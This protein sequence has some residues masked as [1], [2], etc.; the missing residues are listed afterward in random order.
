[1]HPLFTDPRFKKLP[2]QD[3]HTLFNAVMAKEPRW[4]KTPP[5]LRRQI[6]AKVIQ[7]SF[8]I[9]PPPKLEPPE[10]TVQLSQEPQPGV[11]ETL[12][13]PFDPVEGPVHLR[14]ETYQGP[15][16]A[17][18]LA[19]K[20][21][22]AILEGERHARNAL[23]VAE[24]PGDIVQDLIRGSVEDPEGTRDELRTTA[25]ALF[26]G[27]YD[28]MVPDK[29]AH[30]F[31]GV[32]RPQ[33]P[34]TPV[35]E[36]L[37][38]TGATMASWVPQLKATL[39]HLGVS[40]EDVAQMSP[41]QAEF[42]RQ[43]I[44]ENY[45]KAEYG[46]RVA[47]RV[48]RGLSI[49]DA[50]SP[51]DVKEWIKRGF[52]G[53]A[54]IMMAM[55]GAGVL[56]GPGAAIPVA[57]GMETASISGD[58]YD[59]TGEGSPFASIVGGTI[60][61]AL[62][63][64]PIVRALRRTGLG[65]EAVEWM[66]SR[67][68]AGLATGAEEFGTEYLQ[69][70]VESLALEFAKKHKEELAAEGFFEHGVEAVRTVAQ[71]V[72][73]PETQREALNAGLIGTMTGG[74]TGA[75]TP[76][77]PAAQS[78]SEEEVAQIRELLGALKPQEQQ[79]AAPE[80]EA[81]PAPPP[82]AGPQIGEE[83][84]QDPQ[85]LQ[86]ALDE[87]RARAADT[88]LAPPHRMQWAN[89]A[90]EVEQRLDQLN[91]EILAAQEP[92]TQTPEPAPEPVSEAAPT[93]AP[94]EAETQ[95]EAQEA[96]RF[97]KRKEGGYTTT[98]PDG[99]EVVVT[100]TTIPGQGDQKETSVWEA[101]LADDGIT[102]YG[103]TRAAAY[104]AA[105]EAQQ[106]GSQAPETEPSPAPEPETA[107]VLPFPTG[108]QQEAPTETAP[109]EA[110]RAP[111]LEPRSKGFQI[112]LDGLD[113]ATV[114]RIRD[115]KVKTKAGER[116]LSYHPGDNAVLVPKTRRDEIA[117]QLEDILEVPGDHEAQGRVPRGEREAGQAGQA[118]A[119][120]GP[121]QDQ[122]A[123]PEEAAAGGVPQAET[124]PVDELAATPRA[125][126][127]GLPAP[128]E[129]TEAPRTKFE[130][131]P[132]RLTRAFE[133][134]EIEPTPYGAI[135]KRNGKEQGRVVLVGQI[136]PTEE[137]LAEHGLTVEEWEEG[138][139][140]IT[141]A[142][143]RVKGRN[144]IRI[145]RGAADDTTLDHEAFHLVWT[146]LS[147]AA[148][149]SLTKK[150]GGEEGAA[151]AYETWEPK[152]GG[153]L[154]KVWHWANR[155]A[156]S[157]GI[158][159]TADYVLG[160]IRSG[161][162][163]ERAAASLEGPQERFQVKSRDDGVDEHTMV[164]PN[165]K[166]VV[167][168]P[169]KVKLTKQERE[170]IKGD[171]EAEARL[172]EYRADHPTRDG[173]ARVAV[174]EVEDG[175]VTYE[176]ASY[177]FHLDPKTKE[178]NEATEARRIKHLARKMAKDVLEV[179]AKA[180]SGD[181]NSNVILRQQGWYRNMRGKLRDVLG[182]NAELFADFLGTFSPKTPVPINWR[183][184]VE[185]IQRFSRGDYDADMAKFKKWID[186]GKSA[187]KY[188]GPRIRKLGG[189]LFGTNSEKGMIAL[190]DMWQKVDKGTSPKAR[191]FTRNLLGYSE[192][193]T[194]DV[195]AARYLQ[196]LAGLRRIPPKM[197][198]GVGGRHKQN[199]AQKKRD[200]IENLKRT[201]AEKGETSSRRRALEKHRAELAQ[202]VT[203]EQLRIQRSGTPYPV[204][205]AFGFAQQV[206][207]EA[208]EMLAK[209]GV[210]LPPA[211]L[212]AVAWFIEKGEWGQK[213]FDTEVGGSFE[214]ELEADPV[215][216]FISGF[217]PDREE[218]QTGERLR[219]TEGSAR[220]GSTKVLQSL[221]PEERVQEAQEGA[222]EA[223]NIQDDPAVISYR[224][225]ETVG[226]YM[227]NTESA[228]DVELT[229][230][231]G[232]S[233]HR[234][235]RHM[236]A[237]AKKYDQDSVFFSRVV[238]PNEDVEGARPGIEVYF[239]DRA[240]LEDAM[241]VID[242]IVG[243]GH[244][245]F[246]FMVDPR[247][248]KTSSEEFTGVRLQYIPEFDETIDMSDPKALA[249]RLQEKQDELDALA[250]TL[251]GRGDVF[252]ARVYDYDTLVV[253]KED[254]DA[255]SSGE[256]ERTAQASRGK[257]WPRHAVRKDAA[258]ADQAVGGDRGQVAA[259]DV[260]QRAGPKGKGE[261]GKRHQVRSREDTGAVE[262]SAPPSPRGR[263]EYSKAVIPKF[264]T[265]DSG[266]VANPPAERIQPAPIKGGEVKRIDKIILKVGKG[267]G[268]I[269][270][271]GKTKKGVWGTYFP[272]SART[273]IKFAGDLDTAAHELA[274]AI[275][276]MFGIAGRLNK[277]REDKL[278]RRYYK[279]DKV[280]D[281]ELE[282]F[283]VY[284]SV[285]EQGPRSRLPYKRAE[286]FAEWLRAY[287]VNPKAAVEAAPN[288]Y[289]LYRETVSDEVH[290]AIEQFS[291]D[292]REHAGLSSTD[293]TLANVRVEPDSKVAKI[294][295]AVRDEFEPSDR[296]IFTTLRWRDRLASK[297]T[298]DLHPLF[299]GVAR[300]L[301]IRGIDHLLPKDDPRTL[302][303]LW[304]GL[305]DKI[306]AIFEMGMVDA[307]NRPMLPGGI[308]WLIG[309]IDPTSDESVQRGY[310]GTISL[311]ISERV[312]EKGRA[313]IDA[314][315]EKA[316][317]WQEA[318][319]DGD[320]T[321]EEFETKLEALNQQVRTKV[322]H[323]SGAGAGIESDFELAQLN[324]E[325]LL[326]G[327]QQLAAQVRETADRYR[328]WSDALLRYMVDKG[329]LSEKEYTKIKDA[330]QQYAAMHRYAEK[331]SPG[332]RS[333]YTGLR[334]GGV[335]DP[336]KRFTGSTKLI[337]NPFV[338]LLAQT[339]EIVKEAD[340]NDVMRSFRDLLVAQRDMYEGAPIDLAA[341][342]R[343]VT[344]TDDNAIEIFVDGKPEYWQFEEG[345]HEALKKMGDMPAVPELARLLPSLLRSAVINSPAF[346]VRN[347]IRDAIQRSIVSRVGSKPW[348]VGYSN[349]EFR[350]AQLF[351]GI[352]AAHY[353]R[354][355]ISYH[356]K[357]KEA[358]EK[359][360]DDPNSI[361]VWPGKF[362]RG[363][364]KMGAMSETVNRMA[365]Y[366][367]AY[368]HAK[369]NLKYDEYNASLYA[370]A[371]ARDLLDFA[372]AG[373]WMKWLN[374]IAPFTN[375]RIRGIAK[376]GT[377]LKEDPIGFLTRWSIYAVFPKLIEMAWAMWDDDE[378]ELAQQ[379]S[380]IQ[381][382]FLN[383]KIG[384]DTWARL[385]LGHDVAVF[386]S[387]VGRAIRYARGDKEAFDGVVGS[388]ARTLFPIDVSAALGPFATFFEIAANKDLFRGRHIISP[389]EEGRA[390]ELRKGA[391]RAS[392]LGQFVSTLSDL[393][394][395]DFLAEGKRIDP[396]YVDY[397]IK[398]QF[399]DFGRAATVLSDVG[400]A[401]KPGNARAVL[402]QT[403]VII[404]GPGR[405]SRD[406]EHVYSRAKYLNY[407][408]K[409]FQELRDMV[410]MTYEAETAKGRAEAKRALREKAAV[411][412][413]KLDNLTPEK[414][415]VD[416]LIREAW[417][418]DPEASAL[419]MYKKFKEEGVAVG[420]WSTFKGRVTRIGKERRSQ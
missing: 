123:G 402:R 228:L 95:P 293:R 12:D 46:R 284:G 286:G 349:E 362:T 161:R 365:E 309:A 304:F 305:N 114:Q 371:Q 248:P 157:L 68:K 366:K 347:T 345:L 50:D 235:V 136:K 19:D 5:E 245:G 364:R 83:L 222:K 52:A 209:E 126:V 98:S 29:N 25:R 307:E 102:G 129:R 191:N 272:G 236:V 250:V 352:Q 241:D 154:R 265:Y 141:G 156:E 370:A 90:A 340:R 321:Q 267:V 71:V 227:K 170:A 44:D 139:F 122:A 301:K 372:V 137:G 72:G 73:D 393:A 206:F 30:L 124:P 280:Y 247:A 47:E 125:A 323:L 202:L 413:T 177:G 201:I 167:D 9:P 409:D 74:T 315:M 408:R 31:G 63:A 194:I 64:L 331:L 314:A 185:A 43:M 257:A 215:D 160:E 220:A 232:W 275:D 233:P 386:A 116:R 266:K 336:V 392:R 356:K 281:P 15:G 260:P 294:K 218:V 337:E 24:L 149:R 20:A 153:L 390:I 140:L 231:K 158:D 282:Q 403:G 313:V 269:V 242:A 89:R 131:H 229:V 411:L 75:M 216:R 379:P 81:A 283:W 22:S 264:K 175:T 419:D 244:D 143:G 85:A 190:L 132:Q 270:R 65:D 258:G 96:P 332:Y 146:Q 213:G 115:I 319:D 296:G 414:V 344:K 299:K 279:K 203:E 180:K 54:P 103:K 134:A 312:N 62:E 57:M 396:R 406:V 110:P 240:S 415:D 208:S 388:A 291:I 79:E 36:E 361:I 300:S 342:G 207:R 159:P 217:S 82:G 343:K 48:G 111:T 183:Y 261:V 21:R 184:A 400:R 224:S 176:E 410:A 350:Q 151:T 278:G 18:F 308:D 357:M 276:D 394:V 351:G 32:E 41:E 237:L 60:A 399:A 77:Q 186:A 384:G 173:W 221:P 3:Q 199:M 329:R 339:Y 127:E 251:A 101:V 118:E 368:Q 204:G 56:A 306:E 317:A 259:G 179:H 297:I 187:A 374:Q 133:G 360:S 42:A 91:D 338:N 225:P 412:R 295:Q 16:A 107:T 328:Q 97:A 195:W 61:G 354:D 239:K 188:D 376:S 1:M 106:E 178:V 100:R 196:R 26:E 262:L 104:S 105:L 7:E 341:V 168:D 420:S 358:L 17:E 40:E 88:S 78:L 2:T 11:S 162:A 387:A 288:V 145:A 108:K 230:R 273:L 383:F 76:A 152:Q 373:S 243:A 303:R 193:A 28:A 254:Y 39:A 289:K 6:R 223:A 171:A 14:E 86:A 348:D 238:Q 253:F 164:F 210:D 320:M 290:A 155:L 292:V 197:E 271:K 416:G 117:A 263:T 395:P 34:E 93:P 165:A 10:P 401:D 285:T 67:L 211:D 142:F 378:D 255:Y 249:Q 128:R 389:W 55:I 135:I 355:E 382:L 234:W 318:V 256:P 418:K 327:D 45:K 381:D 404:E 150:F 380:Y 369:K 398:N 182:G 346:M 172:R 192:E 363:W 298:D 214:S 121:V 113:E 120:G 377:A 33:V 27:A 99:Q 246:T 189:A 417:E 302:V 274:H 367:K 37:Y 35:G 92:P 405:F 219:E 252:D 87:A 109:E 144:I 200:T 80:Q 268:R 212:Q 38:R 84:P 181:H 335:S 385:P 334:P 330:N 277:Y 138:D 353:M 51:E 226:M 147:E 23:G 49:F 8:R 333:R 69:T 130:I 174:S 169:K 316:E 397:F 311:L 391:K 4:A 148:R 163:S 375:A 70:L 205:G 324:I 53:Q 407:N 13:L 112:K 66:A 58:I 359:L 198:Q 326:E 287:I 59:E 166:R 310:R 322:D 119:P 94:P 325:D